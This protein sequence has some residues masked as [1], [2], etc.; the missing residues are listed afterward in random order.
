MV[1]VLGASLPCLSMLPSGQQQGQEPEEET[2][3]DD[4]AGGE[5]L[6]C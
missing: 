5:D 2:E 6:V 1:L 3:D 4:E